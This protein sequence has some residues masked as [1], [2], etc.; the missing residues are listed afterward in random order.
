MLTKPQVFYDDTHNQALGYQNPFY[1]KKAQRI[2]PTLYD[3]SIISSQH[4]ASLVIDDEKRL[5]LEEAP[6]ELPKMEAAVQQR[7]L[8]KQC[9]E[10]VKKKLFLENDRLLQQIMSHDVLLSVMNSTTLNGESMNLGMQRSES[11]DKCFD[12]DAE[13][14]KSQNAYNDLS[15]CYSQLEKHCFSLELTMQLNQEIFQK[16]SFSNNQNALEILEYF[17]YNDLKARLQAKDTTICKLKEHIKSMRENDKEEKVKHEMDENETIKIEL[18]HRQ[19]QEKVF[20]ITSLKNDLRKLKGKEMVENTAQIPIATTIVPGMFKLDLD[21]L[22]PRLLQNREAYIDYLKHTQEQADI[23]WGIVEQ[24]KANK[25]LDNALNFACKHAKRIQELLVYVRD[26][27]PNAYKPSKKLITVTP[28]NKVKQVRF[29]EPLT[30]SRNIK[31]VE[32]SKTLDSNTP[33]LSSTGLKCFTS[34]C[35]SQPKG[36]K[37]NDRISQT[38]CSKI[39]NKVKAQPRKVN[40]KNH[41][42]EPICDANAKHTMLN[43]NS[44]LICVKCK[45][46]MFDANH[47]VCFIDF[48]NDMNVCSTSKSIKKCQKQNIWKPTGHMFTEIGYK[49]NPTGR[50]FT[51]VGNLRPLT[52]ITHTKIVH[53]KETTPNSGK[54]QKPEIKVYSRRP[55]QVKSIG[56][57]KKAKIVESKIANNLEPTHLWGSNATDVTSSSSLVNDRLSRLFSG[58]S[59]KSSHRPKA[60]DTNQ[61]KLYL[62]HMD[63]CGPM[64]VKSINGKKYI[65][66]IVDEYSRFTWVKFLRSKD[67]APDAIIKCIKNIQVR[68]NATVRNVRTYNG[69]KFVNQTLREFY[70]NVGISHQTFVARTPQQNGVV[71]S[72]WEIYCKR[73]NSG[74]ITVKSG[75][76]S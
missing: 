17:K 49:W 36:N 61:E 72:C 7:S 67:E 6:K 1:L 44:Q 39:K 75:S 32:S 71:K 59:K 48:V 28:M 68:L 25:S 24:A 57:S 45:Q 60:E 52:R 73:L 4:A 11:Y 19:I 3:G 69:T 14:L 70:E 47:D 34:T 27:F 64:R 35:I 10:I 42:K 65:L 13:L 31:Q 15:K 38:P 9:F 56:S 20:V 21:P 54:T 37:R 30:S 33:V 58:K 74:S 18:E 2:K 16:E 66:V 62:L 22:A 40:K 55:K 51:I 43:S 46:C 76:I 26:T 63:L 29:S 8:D 50:L 23:L 5:I 53:L 41:V 12:L